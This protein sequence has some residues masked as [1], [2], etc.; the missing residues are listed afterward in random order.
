MGGQID[1][2]EP[3]S[4]TVARRWAALSFGEGHAVGV[5]GQV[6][7]GSGQW[8][9]IG[10]SWRAGVHARRG[11]C[12]GRELAAMQ[13]GGLFLHRARR[14]GLA[15]PPAAAG[16]PVALVAPAIHGR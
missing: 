13:A 16:W 7:H 12:G 5:T 11:M 14:A 6:R 8:W 3:Q 4:L 10:T 9:R 15:G 2:A 1:V